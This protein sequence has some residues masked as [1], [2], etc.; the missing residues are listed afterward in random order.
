MYDDNYLYKMILNCRVYNDVVNL[1]SGLSNGTASR[2][3]A[4]V[5]A[6]SEVSLDRPFYLGGY[7][8][9]VMLIMAIE[10]NDI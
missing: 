9:I 8:S 1:I 3:H 6:C 5:C 7:Q 4:L 10:V 2:K